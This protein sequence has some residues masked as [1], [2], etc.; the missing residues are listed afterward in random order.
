MQMTLV[1][2]VVEPESRGRALGLMSTAIGVLPIG[3]ILLGLVAE[4]VGVGPAVA[5]SAV[6][7][8]VLLTLWVLRWPEVFRLS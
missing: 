6:A 1:T 5:G 8:V 3:T 7:G 2:A 4:S